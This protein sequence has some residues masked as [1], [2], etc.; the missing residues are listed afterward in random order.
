MYIDFVTN[1]TLHVNTYK[2]QRDKCMGIL[3]MATLNRRGVL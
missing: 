1:A 3:N 2:H